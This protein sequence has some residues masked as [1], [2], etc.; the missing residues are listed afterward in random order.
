[1]HEVSEIYS[2]T[3]ADIPVA[4]AEQAHVLAEIKVGFQDSLGA[5]MRQTLSIL[6]HD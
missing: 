2:R 3:Y 5:A 1:M 6:S 4:S